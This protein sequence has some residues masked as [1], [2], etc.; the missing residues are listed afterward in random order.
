MRQ[1]DIR[2]LDHLLVLCRRKEGAG[3][4]NKAAVALHKAELFF[5]SVHVA[6]FLDFLLFTRRMDSLFL[7]AP[8]CMPVTT[9][10]VH[11]QSEG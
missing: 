9:E 4:V 11:N 3:G 8:Q 2:A 7:V 1:S 6:H 5:S 10:V